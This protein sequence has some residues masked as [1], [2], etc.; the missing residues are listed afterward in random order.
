MIIEI[1]NQLISKENWINLYQHIQQV[2][3]PHQ[4]VEVAVEVTIAVVVH[5]AVDIQVEE[6]DMDSCRFHINFTNEVYIKNK[7]EV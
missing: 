6:E 3:V 7:N 4:V 5:P 1:M 2:T